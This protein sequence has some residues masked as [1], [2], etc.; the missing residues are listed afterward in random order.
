[1]ARWARAQHGLTH[2]ALSSQSPAPGEGSGCCTGAGASVGVGVGVGVVVGA[3]DGAGAGSSEGC[4]DMLGVGM[5]TGVGA[6][7]VGVGA[8]AAGAGNGVRPSSQQSWKQ[9]ESWHASCAS[10]NEAHAC[11]AAAKTLQPQLLPGLTKLSLSTQLAPGAGDGALQQSPVQHAAG[12]A[13]CAAGK[14]SHAELTRAKMS[15]L[16]PLPG[17]TKLSLSV[18]ASASGSGA[19]IGAGAAAFGVPASLQQSWKQHES[20]HASCASGN[21]AHA[22]GAAA[23]MLQPQ[24]LPGLT[25]LALSTQLAPGAGAGAVSCTGAGATASGVAAS[26]QQSWKQHET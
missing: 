11:G 17:L 8:A 2:V 21:E 19:A 25:K 12:H 7:A 1:M 9:H 13:S 26:S 23:K 3:G 20:W 4:G 18:Q 22:C 5:G 15:Q 24:L 14:L 16:H 6:A 10:G